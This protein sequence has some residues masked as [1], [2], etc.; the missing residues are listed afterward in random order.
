MSSEHKEKHHHHHD[1]HHHHHTSSKDKAIKKTKETLETL[2]EG[3][4]I[5]APFMPIAKVL[6]DKNSNS[7]N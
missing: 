5:A 4:A 2:K 6:L 7:T 3:V 1:H